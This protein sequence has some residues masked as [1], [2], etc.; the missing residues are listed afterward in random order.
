MR[1]YDSARREVVPFVPAGTSVTMYTCGNTP[2][3]LAHVG[4]AATASVYDVVR[5]NLHAQ[6][7]HTVLV[8]NITDLDDDIIARSARHG[9]HYLDVADECSVRFR[10]SLAA[11]GL[12]PA[13]HEPRVTGHIADIIT[14]VRGLEASG[15]T[16][17]VNGTVF[18]D[19]GTDAGYGR[20]SHFD[21]ATMTEVS[22]KRGADPS[23][24]RKRN[25]LDFILWQAQA[26]D[27]DPAWPSPWGPGR[28]GWHI[29]CT[30][31]AMRLLGKTID[32]H[33]GGEDL[34][35]PHHECSA[36]QS[37]ALNG[38]VLANHWMHVG[39]VCFAG[40]KMSKSLGNVVYIDEVLEK[41]EPAVVRLALLANHYRTSWAWDEALLEE[42]A[43]RVARWRA[44]GHGLGALPAVRAALNDD[45]DT[46][47]A[48]DQL[49]AA[50]AA[51][52]GVS[53]ACATLLGLQLSGPR[54]WPRPQFCR[55]VAA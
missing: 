37:E 42:A 1:L 14:C 7:F 44:A 35:F 15:R 43:E 11:L 27:H 17:V 36:A 6:G 13:T 25:P 20:V 9:F 3:D 12:L 52:Q 45:L 40:E 34:V 4:H 41:W 55:K 39:M 2:D 51:G 32:L 48:L 53:V 24:P 23:D 47:A 30:A 28:P 22:S 5:R 21:K 29:E 50:V 19:V 49:D 31:M 46:P 16:Y 33:G 10:R 18:F 26:D 54:P 38:Q 8:R